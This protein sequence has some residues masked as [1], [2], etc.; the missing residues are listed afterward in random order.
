MYAKKVVL[1]TK[2]VALLQRLEILKYARDRGCPRDEQCCASAAEAGHLTI[3]ECVREGGC[4]WDVRPS[5]AA[6]GSGQ[7]IT[8]H[9]AGPKRNTNE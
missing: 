3:F 4:P 6:A 9:H 8:A 1:G 5:S 2:S 7:E